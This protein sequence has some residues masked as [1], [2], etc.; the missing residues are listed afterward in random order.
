M[1]ILI[2]L[3]KDLHP[4]GQLILHLLHNSQYEEIEKH[5]QNTYP[6]YIRGLIKMKY[7][8][9]T[10]DDSIEL[11]KL[12]L[13]KSKLKTILGEVESSSTWIDSYRELFRGKKTGAMGTKSACIKKMDKF[14]KEFGYSK[15]IILNATERYIATSRDYAYL[16]QADY[17]IYKNESFM[18]S[19]VENSKLATYCEEIEM[20]DN[21]Q[22]TDGAWNIQSI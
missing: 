3:K 21:N 10:D 14:I 22:I 16:Q 5:F 2:D 9:N 1:K 17:F 11:S 20:L 8:L 15:E 4:I 19:S 7:I 18:G 12:V 6:Q 13:N